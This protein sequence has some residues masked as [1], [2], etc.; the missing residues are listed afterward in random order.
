[1]YKFEERLVELGKLKPSP[2]KVTLQTEKLFRDLV[3]AA[4]ENPGNVEPI[5]VAVLGSSKYIVNGHLRARAL[6][7]AGID[8]ARAHLVDVNDIADVV[9]L[10]IELNMHGSINPL[11]MLDAA[12]FFKKH[13]TEQPALQKYLELEKRVLHQ[14]VRLQIEAFLEEACKKYYRVELPPYILEWIVGFENEKDQALATTEILES[15]MHTKES[16][17]VFPT[18]TDLEVISKSLKP[19]EDRGKD[20]IV[21]SPK[22]GSRSSAKSMSRKEAEDLVRGSSHDGI[23]QCSCGK[24]LLLN[25]K[26]RRVSSITDDRKNRCIRLEEEGDSSPV[27][28]IPQAMLDFMETSPK[29][30][31]RII[32]IGSKKDLEM[33][34][35]SLK[36]SPQMR[37][38]VVLPR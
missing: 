36:G 8:S 12:K 26:T 7:K 23:V 38:L 37:M 22:N 35:F 17:F 25:S 5:A 1:M 28:A 6:E 19:R 11:G 27:F 30:S 2:V 14:T 29:D 15:L 24:K 34:A 18:P 10:H 33:F 21:Y 4:K 3:A 13:R 16:K 9:R 20:V 31:L 32:R